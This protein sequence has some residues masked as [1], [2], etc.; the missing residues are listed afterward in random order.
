VLVGASEK[1]MPSAR[2]KAMPYDVYVPDLINLSDA[3][4]GKIGYGFVSECLRMGTA[5]IF[6]PRSN[7]P[8]ESFLQVTA[9]FT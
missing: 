6:V 2:F 9:L 1:D 8:E 5:L 7:W 3:V 4:L